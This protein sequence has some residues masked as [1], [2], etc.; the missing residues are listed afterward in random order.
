MPSAG[1]P[2]ANEICLRQ[3]KFA[4][5]VKSGC[6]GLMKKSQR[7]FNYNLLETPR[8]FNINRRKAISPAK[9]ILSMKWI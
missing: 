3:V 7:D 6:A 4:A 2:A 1:A 5:Q 8:R 9:R